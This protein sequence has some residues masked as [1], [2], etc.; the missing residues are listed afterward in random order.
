MRELVYNERIRR[1]ATASSA[2]QCGS[3]HPQPTTPCTVSKKRN[4]SFHLHP[5]YSNTCSR[6]SLFSIN[7]PSFS[8]LLRVALPDGLYIKTMNNRLSLPQCSSVA[9][10]ET[11]GEQK[12]RHMQETIKFYLLR[13]QWSSPCWSLKN[14][15][16]SLWLTWFLRSWVQP[17]TI[18]GPAVSSH[19]ASVDKSRKTF[20]FAIS[21]LTIDLI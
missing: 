16:V 8:F 1:R 7:N 21:N 15:S 4:W 3:M 2:A 5:A 12:E 11:G 6:W 10:Q 19:R 17:R 13:A 14:S 18:S 20:N 9:F